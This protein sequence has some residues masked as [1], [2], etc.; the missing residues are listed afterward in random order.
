MIRSESRSISVPWAITFADLALLL[1]C[2]FVML[3]T[4]KE[5]APE[6]ALIAEGTPSS[7]L[8]QKMATLLKRQ[9]AADMSQGWLDITARG[10]SL[11]LQF[12]ASEAF[13][14]GSDHLTQR[15]LSLIDA[16]GTVL[17]N[18]EARIIVIGHTDDIPIRTE[19]FRDNWELSSARA[20]SVIRELINRQD[21]NPA[22]LEA[23]GYAD[24]R[25]LVPNDSEENRARNRRIEIEFSWSR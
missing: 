17:A 4:F 11:H 22:R 8:S 1:L 23:K 24:T 2:F 15:T 10:E 6:P 16:M 21:V 12:G 19:R 20:V 9:F 3:T 13:E 25:P 7:A 14:S 18:N 5:T